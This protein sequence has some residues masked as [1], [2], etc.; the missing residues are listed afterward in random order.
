M[1]S[2]EKKKAEFYKLAKIWGLLSFVPVV[3]A[4]SPVAGYFFGVYLEGKIGFAPYLSLVFMGIGFYAG[5][6]EI[7]K[8]L[9]I[10]HKDDGDSHSA[11]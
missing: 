10:I 6:M 4:A 5:V 2:E 9:R 11:T 1:G 7:I 8:I 3:L